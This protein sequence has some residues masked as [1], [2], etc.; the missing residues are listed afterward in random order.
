MVQPASLLVRLREYHRQLRCYCAI[1]VFMGL[2]TSNPA[3]ELQ[4]SDSHNTVLA[5]AILN[6]FTILKALHERDSK[7]S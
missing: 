6:V 7:H 5:P 4:K 3:L 1:N 2:W